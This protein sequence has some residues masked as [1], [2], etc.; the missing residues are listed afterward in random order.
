MLTRRVHRM[1]HAFS[2]ASITKLEMDRLC[3]LVQI[4]PEPLELRQIIPYIQCFYQCILHIVII[5]HSCIRTSVNIPRI[6]SHEATLLTQ[7]ENHDISNFL[8]S[9]IPRN[10][11]RR[12]RSE[13]LDARKIGSMHGGI[14]NTTMRYSVPEA[15]TKSKHKIL[16]VTR[17]LPSPFPQ[18]L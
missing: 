11:G 16:T 14:N 18:S 9:A 7:Q 2:E 4:A 1:R 6:S 8:C 5:I 15:I 12:G 13:I 3:S 10:W 17:N